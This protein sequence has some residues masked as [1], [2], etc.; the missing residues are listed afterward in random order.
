MAAGFAEGA[1]VAVD[2][3]QAEP[4]RANSLPI[5]YPR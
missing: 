3:H 2:V 1:A 5:G 4:D